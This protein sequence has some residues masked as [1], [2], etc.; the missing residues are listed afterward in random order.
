ML[1][2]ESGLGYHMICIALVHQHV[3]RSCLNS[4]VVVVVLQWRIFRCDLDGHRVSDEYG[5]SVA[6]YMI[7]G[8]VI[9]LKLGY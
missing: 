1:R 2:V 3:G 7:V 6:E 8:K 9:R 5:G 4:A